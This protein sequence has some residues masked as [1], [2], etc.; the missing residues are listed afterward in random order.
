MEMIQI[1]IDQMTKKKF[2]QAIGDQD[3][4]TVIRALIEQYLRRK[5]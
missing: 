1:R 5:K 3:M 2:K 4:S